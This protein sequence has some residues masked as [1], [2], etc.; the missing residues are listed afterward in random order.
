MRSPAPARGP[1]SSPFVGEGGGE[2]GR[3]GRARTVGYRF[4]VLGGP[5][6]GGMGEVRA[7]PRRKPG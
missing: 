3:T 2:W 5:H 6:R 1:E 7:A 4:H